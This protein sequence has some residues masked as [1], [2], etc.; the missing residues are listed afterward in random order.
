MELK[1]TSR[2]DES[3]SFVFNDDK[4]TLTFVVDNRERTFGYQALEP[5]RL[6]VAS[7]HETDKKLPKDDVVLTFI[8]R[9]RLLLAV[10]QIIMHLTDA[11]EVPLHIILEER[12]KQRILT[13]FTNTLFFNK[14]VLEIEVQELLNVIDYQLPG[15]EV[16]DT[17]EPPEE[18]IDPLDLIGDGRV[19]IYV[20]EDTKVVEMT[21]IEAIDS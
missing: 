13:I 4:N 19:P 7:P 11:A 3:I 18:D 15:L 2:T 10:S 8:G 21:G 20:D 1:R 5:R 6:M 17:I 14:D 16:E 9:E 12:Y